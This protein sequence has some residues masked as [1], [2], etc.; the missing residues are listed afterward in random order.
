MK[1]AR[2]IKKAALGETKSP[3]SLSLQAATARQAVA[4][5]TPKVLTRWVGAYQNSRCP[6]PRAAF[7]ALF[8]TEA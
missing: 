3:V 4:R 2:L 1:K 7:A 6:N 5:N 8:T